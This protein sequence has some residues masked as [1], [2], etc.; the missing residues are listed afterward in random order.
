[1]PNF[2]RKGKNMKTYTFKDTYYIEGTVKNMTFTRVSKPTAK[3]AFN[4]GV[5]IAVLPCKMGNGPWQHRL[6]TEKSVY[7]PDFDKF[8]NEYEYYNC[9]AETGNYAAFYLMTENK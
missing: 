8:V 4:Q 9:S 2:R 3:K 7:N 5:R 1:M 6:V